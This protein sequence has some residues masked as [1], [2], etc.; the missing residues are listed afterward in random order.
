[1]QVKDIVGNVILYKLILTY[2]QKKNSSEYPAGRIK[3]V[4]DLV[5]HLS[6]PLMDFCAATKILLQQ[7]ME[8]Y[9]GIARLP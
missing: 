8:Q 1:M 2:R 6:T 5:S 4:R 7:K 3:K 9:V